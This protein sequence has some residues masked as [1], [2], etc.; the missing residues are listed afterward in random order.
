[1]LGI[2]SIVPGWRDLRVLYPVE[3]DHGIEADVEVVGD[4]GE[5]IAPSDHVRVEAE[6]S[7]GAALIGGGAGELAAPPLLA[8]TPLA[9][10]REPREA[11]QRARGQR[12][13]RNRA[14]SNSRETRT[15]DRDRGGLLC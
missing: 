5:G 3:A 9:P 15:T 12:K 7:I 8:V 2:L 6:S 11:P 1:M 10:S 4:P 13:A 14:E